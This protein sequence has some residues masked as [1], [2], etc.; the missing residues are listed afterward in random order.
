MA[1]LYRC[2]KLAN[3]LKT[4]FGKYISRRVQQAAKRAGGEVA[5][6]KGAVKL[7]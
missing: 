5:L 2:N 4:E 1:D 6:N 3:G 7:P